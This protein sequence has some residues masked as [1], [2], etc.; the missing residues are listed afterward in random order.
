MGQRF[1][2]IV[3]IQQYG[4]IRCGLLLD[5][6][7]YI[8]HLWL[9]PIILQRM[10]RDLSQP[11]LVPRY[12]F[13]HQFSNDEASVRLQLIKC[14]SDGKAHPKSADQYARVRH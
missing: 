8:S 11:A 14:C 13:R 7:A 9:N 6:S 4:I 3:Y 2:T 12:Y 5:Q 1:R 10:T